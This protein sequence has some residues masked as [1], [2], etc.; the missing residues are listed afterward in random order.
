MAALTYREA[1]VERV[2]LEPITRFFDVESPE[3][4]D[5]LHHRVPGPDFTCYHPHGRQYEGFFDEDGTPWL[6]DGQGA[7]GRPA[8]EVVHPPF[9]IAYPLAPAL[10]VHDESEVTCSVLRTVEDVEAYQAGFVGMEGGVDAEHQAH[11]VDGRGRHWTL[12]ASGTATTVF[13]SRLDRDEHGVTFTE[14]VPLDTERVP[15]PITVVE[16]E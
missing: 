15:L 12:M 10:T 1:S 13:A 6:R 8:L 11:A 4:L 2:P 14:T 16:I 3:D 9:R 5:G 7:T